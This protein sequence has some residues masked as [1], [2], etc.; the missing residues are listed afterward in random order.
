ML[1]EIITPMFIIQV[2]AHR[3]SE[4]S[5]L[6]IWEDN[7]RLRPTKAYIAEISRKLTLTKYDYRSE[8]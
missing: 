1:C 8:C 5:E 7:S 6:L 2:G 3:Q 4:P